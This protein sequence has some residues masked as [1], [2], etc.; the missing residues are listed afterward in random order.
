ME[1]WE[2]GREGEKIGRR[3]PPDG[4]E[5][6]RRL[7][8]TN[9]IEQAH[10]RNVDYDTKRKRILVTAE[11]E[12]GIHIWDLRM[13]KFPI[14]EL[15]GIHTECRNRL[16]CQLWLASLPS[17]D[18]LSLESLVESPTRRKDPLLNSYSDCED[19]V[20]VDWDILHPSPP[21]NYSV[22]AQ[23][24]LC[25]AMNVYLCSHVHT[26]HTIKA[27]SHSSPALL[28]VTC[29]DQKITPYYVNVTT[30]GL[31]GWPPPKLQLEKPVT[32]LD[33]RDV[34]SATADD[35]GSALRGSGTVDDDGW[36]GGRCVSGGTGLRDVDSLT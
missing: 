22:M 25:V 32:P 11:D 36:D 34:G 24:A 15:P 3:Q 23:M 17:S 35:L 9:S 27:S 29:P 1:A 4:G 18:N 10:M 26:I 13:P 19:S 20:Y 28:A 31:A 30:D 7:G 5:K 16:N 8:K 12:S 33:R 6:A 2:R 14:L 21:L